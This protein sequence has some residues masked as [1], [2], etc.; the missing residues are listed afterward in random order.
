MNASSKHQTKQTKRKRIS[1]Q[2]LPTLVAVGGACGL[3]AM[4]A[5]ALELGDIQVNSALGQPLRASIAYAL[6]PNEQIHSYCIYLRPGGTSSGTRSL[7]DAKIS[8]AGNTILVTGTKPVREPI[9]GLQIA[10]D[11]AY[12]PNLARE[13][14]V[15]LNPRVPIVASR[16]ATE[17]VIAATNAPTGTPSPA[18]ANTI[19]GDQQVARGTAA[20]TSVQADLD[21]NTLYR[22]RPGDTV[23][24]IVSRIQGRTIGL[25]PAVELVF[26]ANPGAFVNHDMNRLIAGSEILIPVF[27]D[28]VATSGE[29]AASS[30]E[31]LIAEPETVTELL[32]DIAEP[33]SAN[34]S[35]EL[36]VTAAATDPTT[37]ESNPEPGIDPND[38][39]V[40]EPMADTTATTELRPGDVIVMPSI[41]ESAERNIPNATT[42]KPLVTTPLI[43]SRPAKSTGTSGAWS[44]LLWLGGT[45]VAL[46]IGLLIFGRT[47]RERFGASGGRAAE[48]PSRR[49]DDDVPQVSRIV[50]DVDFEFEDT[51]NANAISL[52]ADLDAGTGLNGATELDV[53]QDFGFSSTGQAEGQLDL[54]I[55]EAAAREPEDSPTDVIPPNHREEPVMVVESE[56]LPGEDDNEEYD[57]SMIVDATKQPIGDYDATAKDL[58]A[59]RLDA[60]AAQE[61]DYTMSSAVDYQALEQDYQEEFTA[62]QAANAEME[63]IALE[64]ASRID[65]DDSNV[66]VEMPARDRDEEPAV[67]Q[68]PTVSDP[69]LTAE[70]TANLRLTMEAENDAIADDDGPEITV[71]M[72]AAGSDITIDLPVDSRKGK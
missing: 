13:Y 45:G 41:P 21:Q 48:L 70:L 55:T 51:I 44:W 49:Q 65:E 68:L 28:G 38:G 19:R 64:L 30:P 1:P 69:D 37:A 22:V 14:T 6:N 12:T 42:D 15:L 60:S 25:W 53:A 7:D 71:E 17:S 47:M 32:G 46:I 43:D 61:E 3:S 2:L 23:S 59:V 52:D 29:F 35:E 67:D 40:A 66:T 58:Q 20:R 4:P 31:P 54:E 63:R 8:L 11:C 16:P 10:V 72:S 27:A 9:V 36:P 18:E 57:L 50:H 24:T 26:A 62:T 34:V 5:D 39:S 56:D 33:Y